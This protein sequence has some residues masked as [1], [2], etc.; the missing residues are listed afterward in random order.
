MKN[1][2]KK[3]NK[4][5]KW[6]LNW[7][8]CL[9]QL[10]CLVL[11]DHP[12]MYFIKFF[13]VIKKK[14]LLFLYLQHKPYFPKSQRTP[15]LNREEHWGFGLKK[16]KNQLPM[17]REEQHPRVLPE[18]LLC[19]ISMMDIPINNQNFPYAQFRLQWDNSIFFVRTTIKC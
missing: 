14:P 18:H 16:G 15:T 6:K 17:Y 8:K 4:V 9:I 1:P 19:T 12:Y 7:E 10:Y 3:D 11:D 2:E 5:K 13:R